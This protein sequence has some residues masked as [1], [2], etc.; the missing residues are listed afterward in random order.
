MSKIENASEAEPANRV[1]NAEAA[2]D[3]VKKAAG[4]AKAGA[5]TLHGNAEKATADVEKS[6][7]S[8]VGEFAKLARNAQQAAFED[9]EAFFSNVDKIASATTVREAARIYGDY[10]HDRN[11]VV[12]T[13]VRAASDYVAKFFTDG[14]KTAQENIAKLGASARKAA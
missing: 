6:L 7:V 13:R 3:F 8:A 12:L 1:I 10:L 4:S 11:T 5:V 14:A 9:A 2:R